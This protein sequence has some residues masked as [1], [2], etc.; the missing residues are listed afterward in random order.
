[1]GTSKALLDAIQVDFDCKNH[2]SSDETL[3]DIRTDKSLKNNI[4][5]MLLDKNY[6]PQGKY[7][8]YGKKNTSYQ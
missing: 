6:K 3:D 8:R 2:E 5:I 1:M 4:D 7:L